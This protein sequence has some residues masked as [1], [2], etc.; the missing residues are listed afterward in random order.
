MSEYKK[1][2]TLEAYFEN[3]FYGRKPFMHFRKISFICSLFFAPLTNSCGDYN[4]PEDFQMEYFASGF[5]GSIKEYAV[6]LRVSHQNSDPAFI[7]L[8]EDDY[9]GSRPTNGKRTRKFRPLSKEEEEHDATPKITSIRTLDELYH[10]EKRQLLLDPKARW[11]PD[12]KA[13]PNEQNSEINLFLLSEALEDAPPTRI[14]RELDTQHRRSRFTV[15]TTVL[16]T[17]EEEKDTDE[18]DLEALTD[19][20]MEP[21]TNVNFAMMEIF[22]RS[23]QRDNKAL[24]YN[25]LQRFNPDTVTGLVGMTELDLYFKNNTDH[26]INT[27]S[28]GLVNLFLIT[29]LDAHTTYINEE[30]KETCFATNV[31]ESSFKNKD[32]ILALIAQ[33]DSPTPT[34]KKTI[35]YAAAPE[36]KDSLSA[37]KTHCRSK[38]VSYSQREIPRKV[39]EPEGPFQA[40]AVSYRQ[41][42]KELAL[43]HFYVPLM[44]SIKDGKHVLEGC[45]FHMARSREPLTFE[46]LGAVVRCI[47]DSNDEDLT[48]F[49]EVLKTH[50]TIKEVDGLER[51]ILW[52]L[53]PYD[54]SPLSIKKLN[55]L[56]NAGASAI[57]RHAGNESFMEYVNN[58]LCSVE[59][60]NARDAYACCQ[61]FLAKNRYLSQ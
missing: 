6:S 16:S 13:L 33:H 14:P 23:S 29:G 26:G 32:A 18:K 46:E 56:L 47:D 50:A 28:T 7:A 20:L 2:S 53:I 27:L 22:F 19:I 9:T 15:H 51:T 37:H 59:Q 55:L 49:E 52:S 38:S 24:L 30:G 12:L 11:M 44:P 40:V 42:E 45:R 31:K 35:P 21:D 8:Q 43:S 41:Q 58:P 10:K 57:R 3:N 1:T 17:A 39:R 48:F 25:L 61:E 34:K 54:R 60:R 5:Q 4:Y 36:K